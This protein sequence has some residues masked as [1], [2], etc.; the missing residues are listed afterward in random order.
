MS[1]RLSGNRC[2]EI[3]RVIVETFV[4]FNIHC[5]PIS[6]FE[7]A[8]KLGATII[9]Y[10]A[11][12]NDVKILMMKLSEDGFSIEESPGEWYIYYNDEKGYGRVNNTIMHEIGH[13]VLNHSQES[14]LADAEARFF[15]K[16]AL[17][18]PVLI[19]RLNLRNAYEIASTFEIS[20]EAAHYAYSYYSKWLHYGDYNFTD[21]ETRLLKL[22]D[23]PA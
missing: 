9:P 6:G 10:S 17:A 12:S 15:A 13:I 3:K 22:F 23:L 19:H 4:N 16:Y 1:F 14:E 5:V 8:S 7:M 20:V 11:Y 21:Y 18:P 2:E